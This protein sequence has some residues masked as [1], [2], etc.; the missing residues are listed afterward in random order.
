[1]A[2]RIDGKRVSRKWWIVLRAAERDGVPFLLNSGQRTMDEQRALFNQNMQLVGGR[3]VP[4]PGRPLTA[5]PNASAPHIRVGRSDHALD[6]NSLDGGETRLERW[7]E[8]QGS[9]IEWNNTVAGESWHGEVPADDL[10]RLAAR[11]EPLLVLVDDEWRWVRELQRGPKADRRKV[12]KRVLTERRKDIWRA[13]NKKGDG[14][15]NAHHR[16]ERYAILNRLT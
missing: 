5:V 6:V 10:N 2:N 15:W 11:F 9:H 12:L 7:V 13:A 1:M 4:R 8:D 16:A 14:G 3:W